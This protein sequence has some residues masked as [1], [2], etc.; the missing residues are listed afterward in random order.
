MRRATSYMVG[1]MGTYNWTIAD[2]VGTFMCWTLAT[3]VASTLDSTLVIRPRTLDAADIMGTSSW[4]AN[5][6]VGNA[7]IMDATTTTST[8]A[9]LGMTCIFINFILRIE[10]LV[11]FM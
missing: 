8:L 2:D 7:F 1:A 3:V 11:N 6:A 10:I 4:R 9:S 5:N